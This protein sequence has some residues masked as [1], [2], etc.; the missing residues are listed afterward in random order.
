[1]THLKASAQTH[2]SRTK[3]KREKTMAVSSKNKAERMLAT[4]RPK[5][6]MMTML[7]EIS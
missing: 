4:P 7:A 3:M 6:R 5:I 1:M 2:L